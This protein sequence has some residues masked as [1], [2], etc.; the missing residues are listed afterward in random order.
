MTRTFP[1]VFS[2]LAWWGH[3]GWVLVF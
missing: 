1:F 3:C 2:I